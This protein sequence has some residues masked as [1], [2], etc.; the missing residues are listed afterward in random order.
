MSAASTWPKVIGEEETLD[1]V[2]SGKS[3]ARY[4]DGE[5]KLC[6][7]GNCISQVHVSSL[8]RELKEVLWNPAP[9]CIVGTVPPYDSPKNWFWDKVRSNET[10]ARL[11]NPKTAY[12]SQWITRPDNAP[13][14]DTEAFWGRMFSLWRGKDV[15]LVAGSH[16]SLTKEKLETARSVELI[17]CM[18]RDTWEIVD[19]LEKKCLASPN[20]IILLCCGATA[21]VLANRLSK[22]GKHALDLGHIGMFNKVYGKFNLS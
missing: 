1:A 7:G 10:Y 18:Y 12:Y 4:G 5:L 20:K 13:W 6:V 19:D 3:I 14:I 16:R 11:H 17:E 21:T 15:T 8:E 2:L 9:E 22:H